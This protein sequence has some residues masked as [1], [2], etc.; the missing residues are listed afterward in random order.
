MNALKDFA[1][2]L[3]KKHLKELAVENL[4]LLRSMHIPMMRFFADV[5]EAKLLEMGAFIFNRFLTSV[6]NNETHIEVDNSLKNWEEDKILSGI[7]KHDIQPSELIFIYAARQKA[8]MKFIPAYTKNSAE[9]VKIIDELFTYHAEFQDKAIQT[10]YKVRNDTQTLLKE[11]EGRYQS[12]F[13]SASDAIIATDMKFNITEW[14]KAA[15]E[16]YG[17]KKEE[18]L[19][20]PYVDVIKVIFEENDTKESINEKLRESGEWQ[21][22]MIHAGK[23]RN[24]IHVRTS[25]S[26]IKNSKGVSIGFLS[27]TSDISSQKKAEEDLK[28]SQDF[29]NSVIENIPNMIF[30]KDAEELKF[31][32]LNKA[33]ED[34]LGFAREDLLRKSDY[35]FFPKEEADFFI[36]KDRLVLESGKL[37]EIPEEF[38]HTKYKGV[39]ILETKKIPIMSSDGHPK[40]LLGISNDI[41]ERKKVE[42]EL[43]QKSS[44][45]LRSNQE[46]EQFAYVASHDLQEP[47]RMV[48]SYLQLLSNRYAD[49]LDHDAKDFIFYA[50]DGAVRMRNLINSLLDYSRVNRLKAFEK[51]NVTNILEEILSDMREQIKGAGI[52]VSYENLPNVF[53]DPVLIAQLISNLVSNAVKFRNEKNPE[54][55]ITGKKSN[56]ETLFS[57]EDNGIGIQKEYFDKIFVIF[58]RLNNKEKYPGTGIGLAICKKIVERHGGKI[59]VESELNKGAKFYFTIKDNLIS[60]V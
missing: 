35:D 38:I 54:I 39:R 33:G 24:G 20:K 10:L 40:Y 45:L 44:E 53:G 21:G 56:G 46:L 26:V 23:N 9:A 18:V 14:N 17:Y 60:P 34:L 7:S 19:G 41:T 22:E 12:L 57:V 5:P 6:E 52:K 51:L 25:S 59:W 11:K 31:V 55:K 16:L 4:R 43:K 42:N 1:A 36:N 48:T 15:E 28:N 8:I 32:G 37:E 49:K 58:Q 3:R 50:V 30:V 13:E 47:L 2:Y 27:L 29:L